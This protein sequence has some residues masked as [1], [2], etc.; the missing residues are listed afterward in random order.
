MS[1]RH[2]LLLS[3]YY[4][5]STLLFLLTRREDLLSPTPGNWLLVCSRTPRVSLIFS[6]ITRTRLKQRRYL[7]LTLHKFSLPSMMRPLLPKSLRLNLN[8][9]VVSVIGL[10][11]LLFS[12][13]YSPMSLP[14]RPRLKLLPSNSKKLTLRKLLW[15]LKSLS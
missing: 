1:R 15:R 3:I 12:T 2:L 9:L 5:Q 4:V 13:M 7:P 14:S 10:E 6:S 11:T 8:V